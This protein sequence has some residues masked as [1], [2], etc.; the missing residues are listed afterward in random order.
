M[1][2][3]VI[4][5]IMIMVL[6]VVLISIG[7]SSDESGDDFTTLTKVDLSNA[8][9]LTINSN[10][11]GRYNRSEDSEINKL[12][13]Y[14]ENGNLEVVEFYDEN[15]NI[16]E[17]SVIY[18]PSEIIDLGSNLFITFNAADDY[19]CSLSQSVFIEKSTGNVYMV[20]DDNLSGDI[21]LHYNPNYSYRQIYYDKDNNIYAYI[22]GTT[23]GFYKF[24]ISS[25]VA[26]GQLLFEY[27]VTCNSPR[28][29][30][31]NYGNIV[32][33]DSCK[34][35]KIF[36]CEN[37]MS[38]LTPDTF[39]YGSILTSKKSLIN[40]QLMLNS[41]GMSTTQYTNTA[42]ISVSQTDRI[43]Y[44][45]NKTY[46][47]NSSGIIVYDESSS[48]K[49]NN[50]QYFYP[51]GWTANSADYNSLVVSNESV[52]IATNNGIMMISLSDIANVTSESNILDDVYR[53]TDMVVYSDHLVFNGK[54]PYLNYI[55]GKYD[56]NT[57]NITII[58]NYGKEN[59][60]FNL[61]KIN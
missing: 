46:I 48:D 36:T 42:G 30:T 15:G 37:R 40:G 34:P 10:T 23:N 55:T 52:Y 43:T 41:N 27:E 29:L 26:A 19:S 4:L 59:F 12:Y 32:F 24:N 8:R 25:G 14:T 28:F 5:S 60:A 1:K 35:W 45:E 13:K 44:G 6:L 50:V 49:D 47:A 56:F 11:T 22:K 31:D 16:I 3:S 21:Y 20:G 51:A 57:S 54:D 33:E 61:I 7:C 58:K 38:T 17:N 2:K 53:V 18:S 39:T 9:G